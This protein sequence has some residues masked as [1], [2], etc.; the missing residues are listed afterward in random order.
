MILRFLKSN[1]PYHFILI[2]VIVLVLW[3]RSFL[4]PYFFPFFEGESSMPLYRPVHQLLTELPLISNVIAG[5]LVILLSF[6][7]LHLNTVYA[8]IQI[9]TFLP[10][11]IFVLIVSGLVSL[12]TLH[13]VFFGTFFLLICIDSLFNITENE[14]ANPN[15]FNPGFYLSV[16]SL[17]YLN[18][19]FYLPVV[20]VAFLLLRKKREW[21]DFVMSLIGMALPWLFAF[22]WYF[23]TDSVDELRTVITQNL[24]TSNLFFQGS[25][26]FQIYLAFLTITTLWCSFFLIGQYDAKKSSTRKYFKIFFVIFA[27]SIMLFFLIPAASQEILVIMAVPLT[28]LFSNYLISMKSQFLGNLFILVFLGLIIYMQFA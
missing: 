25:V 3:L 5:I 14:K 24:F 18:L 15:S 13:P 2:P 1:Q 21:R 8:F 6:M 19:I 4:S 17:F 12:H 10:S 7:I 27:I 11:N 28:F 16:G 26:T 9:R 23:M 20:W 22:S